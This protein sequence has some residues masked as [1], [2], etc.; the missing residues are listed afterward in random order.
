MKDE[1][2]TPGDVVL[3]ALPL[4]DP[5]G[6]EQEGHRPAIVVG[7]PQGPVRYPV[8]VAVPLT[9]QS[10]PWARKNPSLYRHLPR[11]AGGIPQASIALLDQLRAVDVRR[12]KAYLGRL[13]PEIF[14]PIR[15]S[16]IE[17]FAKE[18]TP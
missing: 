18:N 14:Q 17:L 11:G 5:K 1:P 10:G 7:I 13:E 15:N 9:T 2:L 4:H 12:V 3:I 16:L 6:H 8:V